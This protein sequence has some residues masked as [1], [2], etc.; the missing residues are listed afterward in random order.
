M[1]QK[2][3]LNESLSLAFEILKRIP[4]SR[5]ITAKELQLQL[6]EIGMDRSIRSLQRMLQTLS[7]TLNL[8]CDDRSKPYGYK[9][10]NANLGFALPN[11]SEH[12]SLLLGL[13]QQYLS[14]LLPANVS[15]SLSGFFQ[16]AQ[17]NLN[18]AES[19]DKL[20]AWLKKVRVVSE[21]QPLLAPE[22][23]LEVM[24]TVSKGLFENRWLKLQFSNR[25]AEQKRANVM[26]LGIAQQGNRL[27]LV[28]R[29]EGHNNERSIAVHRIQQAQLSSFT[30]EPP[31]EFDLA[32][33]DNDGRFGF[34]EGKQCRL[35]FCINKAQGYFL[36]ETPLSHD[37]EIEEQAEQ[38]SV[39]A[40]VTD[41]LFLHRWLKGFGEAVSNI[42]TEIVE[43]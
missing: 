9:L 29:F 15:A 10:K 30:F 22:I 23:D 18:S 34:G 31:A 19:P 6:N 13:S 27:Y 32:Q 25:K 37:Q 40:T 42:K 11:L 41:S 24:Q 16:Q 38:L 28:C 35:Q 33:Y 12:E 14:H 4:R 5:Y 21:T 17:Y 8:E 3:S 7:E 2:S 39:S 20:K 36:Y 43:L 26:P 1:K